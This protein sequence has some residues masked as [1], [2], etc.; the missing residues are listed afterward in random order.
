MGQPTDSH[1]DVG[2]AVYKGQDIQVILWS[3]SSVIDPGKET[4]TIESIGKLLSPLAQSEV[5]A[6]RCIGLNVSI[7]LMV[8]SLDVKRLRFGAV[9][10]TR[11]RGQYGSPE[12]SN[13]FLVLF[14][15]QNPSMSNGTD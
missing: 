12:Y 3:G 2:T 5:G 11:S 1:V 9:Q 15:P 7:C 14:S 4:E 10:K 6:I 13:N 8:S